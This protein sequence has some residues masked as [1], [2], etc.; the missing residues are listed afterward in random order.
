MRHVP[1]QAV[2]PTGVK[3]GRTERTLERYQKYVLLTI[4]LILAY[5]G[6]HAAPVSTVS[7]LLGWHIRTTVQLL[8]TLRPASSS[9]TERRNILRG[10]ELAR[11]YISNRYFIC[12]HCN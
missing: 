12:G 10:V 3:F 1:L 5:G 2:S 6:N 4:I 11:C 7:V 8:R 9:E